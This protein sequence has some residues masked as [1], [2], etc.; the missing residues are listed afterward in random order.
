MTLLFIGDENDTMAEDEVRGNEHTASN[1]IF[2]QI[3]PNPAMSSSKT[4][5]TIALL[6]NRRLMGSTDQ[7][8]PNCIYFRIS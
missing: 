3:N 6:F 1:N 4:F 7:A 2:E 8:D 5:G